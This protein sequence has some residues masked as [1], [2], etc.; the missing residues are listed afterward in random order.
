MPE[1]KMALG[2]PLALLLM[3]V[4]SILP[5]LYFRRKGWL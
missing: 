4:S 5:I 3:V 2:Y 1:L